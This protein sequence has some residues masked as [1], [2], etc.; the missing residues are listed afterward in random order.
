[1]QTAWARFARTGNPGWESFDTTT[2]ATL[3]L[4]RES[5][6]EH[7]PGRGERLAQGALP[8]P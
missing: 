2:R 7:D 5:R 4:D 8:S 6:V 1:M 3:M